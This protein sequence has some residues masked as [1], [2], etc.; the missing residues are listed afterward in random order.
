MSDAENLTTLQAA[1]FLNISVSSLYKLIRNGDVKRYKILKKN[2]FRKSELA[3]YLEK[4][5]VSTVKTAQ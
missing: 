1:E 4:L 3:E 5:P 2:V